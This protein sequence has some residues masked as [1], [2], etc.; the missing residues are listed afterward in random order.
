M[1]KNKDLKKEENLSEVEGALTRT[2]QFIED[3][4]K[5]LTIIIG[6]AVL[7]VGGFLGFKKLY[8]QPREKDAQEQMFMAEQYFEKDS[9]NLAING[10][11]NYLGFLDIIDEYGMTK[12]ANLAN[13][14]TGI[15]YLH[16]GQFQDAISYL[17]KF[18]TEDLLLAPVAVGAE[19]DAFMELNETD[20]A[21]NAYKKAYSYK[22][23]FTTP[24][25]LMKAGILLESS[26]KLD[27]ALEAY[28]EI[29]KNY[30]ESNEGRTIEKYIARAEVKQKK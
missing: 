30:P 14:Y 19:G 2:E 29:R 8:V 9:F 26:G 11:G 22:N 5:T 7:I 28:N 4:Q 27:E 1:A 12:A 3:H 17:D 6:V 25:Y 18:E 20:K 23:S 21:L 15:S 10:D 13:Y 16:T 24:V